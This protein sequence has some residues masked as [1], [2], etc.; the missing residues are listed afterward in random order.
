MNTHKYI[1]VVSFIA[2]LCCIVWWS[3]TKSIEITPVE[4]PSGAAAAHEPTKDDRKTHPGS[5]EKDNEH[6][7]SEHGE[8]KRPKGGKNWLDWVGDNCP[9]FS[10]DECNL[11]LAKNGRNSKSY[12]AL[13]FCGPLEKYS[14]YMELAMGISGP[15]NDT[16]QAFAAL[17]HSKSSSGERLEKSA[18]LS[19]SFPNDPTIASLRM[20]WLTKNGK[21]EEVQ[22]L[23]D[24][25]DGDQPAATQTF[26]GTLRSLLVE[27]YHSVG[28]SEVSGNLNAVLLTRN[29]PLGHA[30]IHSVR[31][32][33]S[34]GR[35]DQNQT[36]SLL[37]S[38]QAMQGD[39]DLAMQSLP[40]QREL[41]QL[42]ESKKFPIDYGIDIQS[43]R[44]EIDREFSGISPIEQDYF[45]D[46]AIVLS[47]FPDAIV[48]E[49][50][51]R[52]AASGDAM[53]LQWLQTKGYGDR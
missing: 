6:S 18:L 9:R 31:R 51:S 50:L 1:K 47:K 48:S 39:K 11:Y 44:N 2:A 53:A 29:D 32:E 16:W 35:L 21:F 45:R 33:F 41:V 24:S 8:L 52:S 13:A 28:R 49:F 3:R 23:R 5:P 10:D 26:R 14:Q 46:P 30:I 40:L 27:A 17:T 12:V 7:D 19:E 25:V 37:M 43:V 22:K 34:E 20:F 36:A 4:Q 15:D 38:L 42:A